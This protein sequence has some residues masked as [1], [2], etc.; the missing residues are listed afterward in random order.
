[1]V[2]IFQSMW[3]AV[4]S[5]WRYLLILPILTIQIFLCSLI[6]TLIFPFA[7]PFISTAA[8]IFSYLIAMRLVL[9]SLGEGGALQLLYLIWGSVLF[10]MAQIVILLGAWW[11]GLL[12]LFL[13]DGLTWSEI[14]GVLDAM[15][16]RGVSYRSDL[17]SLGAALFFGLLVIGL[18]LANVG[19]SVPMAGIAWAASE[20]KP[21]VSFFYGFGTRIMTLTVIAVAAMILQIWFG[22]WFASLEFF[23][24]L[25]GAFKSLLSFEKPV[26]PPSG[27]VV[28][29]FF[30]WFANVLLYYW[31]AAAAALAFL[32]RY[33]R[34]ATGRVAL[35]EDK[36]VA[37][38]VGA[39]SLRKARDG[40]RAGP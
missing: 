38:E 16:M 39:R 31:Q 24:W 15:L 7:S 21:D 4:S 9:T 34:E 17:F 8:V 6:A 10:G 28:M 40:A 23:H 33:R 25:N 27:S 3:V 5:V 29:L 26:P 14:G 11:S 19:L 2:L 37:A 22:L 36:T 20:Q 13:A 35:R 12:G 32:E 18:I 30:K 1:M